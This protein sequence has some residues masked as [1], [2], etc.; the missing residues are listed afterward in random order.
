MTASEA[1][2]IV[3]RYVEAW[4]AHDAAGIVAS[5]APA[6]TY[7]DP[8]TQ[9]PIGGAALQ[10]FTQACLDAISQTRFDYQIHAVSDSLAYMTWVWT[11]RHTGAFNG[12]P[13]TNQPVRVQGVDVITFDA[14]G[15][16]TIV[17]YYDS[18]EVLRQL[19]MKL[20]PQPA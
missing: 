19:G 6:G 1:V 15:I 17:G 11:G 5:F 8:V 13:P 20:V 9:Q 7:Q 14:T 18:A 12:I 16:Q 10:G 2:A 3:R 4:N